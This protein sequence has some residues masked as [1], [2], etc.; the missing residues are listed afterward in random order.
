MV[1]DEGYVIEGDGYRAVKVSTYS[2]DLNQVLN[3]VEEKEFVDMEH[4]LYLFGQSIGGM[5]VQNVAAQRQV[6]IAGVIV[7]YGAIGD[8]TASLMDGYEELKA[9]PYSNGEVLF[10]NFWAYREKYTWLPLLRYMI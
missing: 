1:T 4:L 3:F 5:T 2:Q 9:A 6:E 8:A 10:R 7:L